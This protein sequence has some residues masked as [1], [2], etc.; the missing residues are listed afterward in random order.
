MYSKRHYTNRRFLDQ[1]HE[2]VLI[3][4]GAMGTNL[5]DLALTSEHF[6][7]EQYEGCND[8]L[9]ISYPSAVEQVHRSFLDA[10]VDVIETN[11]FR[12]NRITLSEYDLDSQV[13][14]INRAAADLARRIAAEYST[15]DHPRFVAG[16]VVELLQN[17]Q[18][19]GLEPTDIT[20]RKPTLEDVFISLTGR[21]L[22][23]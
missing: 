12:A 11:T 19:A 22:R 23:E 4:D 7:G 2:H 20:I 10:G 18:D 3:Y 6:G 5:Q 16:V 9:V 15:P 13:L 17:L 21:G 1:L 8:Y 14:E